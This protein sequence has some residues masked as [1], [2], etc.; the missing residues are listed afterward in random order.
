MYIIA[1]F[2]G[3]D[4]F[5]HIINTNKLEEKLKQEVESKIHNNP[6][7]VF[8]GSDYFSSIQEGV[9]NGKSLFPIEIQAMIEIYLD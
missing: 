1:T 8:F 5:T 2:F 6:Y 3:D 9:V 4:T 7:V